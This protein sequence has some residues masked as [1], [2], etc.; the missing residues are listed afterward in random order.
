MPR[1]TSG[2]IPLKEHNN[3][4]QG[5]TGSATEKFEGPAV[6]RQNKR[7]NPT[8]GGGINRATKGKGGGSAYE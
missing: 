7:M 1:A 4:M 3:H 8:K 5:R 6:G 2:N